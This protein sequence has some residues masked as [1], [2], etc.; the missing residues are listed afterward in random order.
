MVTFVPTASDNCPGVTT[1]S[2]P[3]S[4]SVFPVG[5]TLVTVTATDA[6]GNT[7]VCTFNVTVNDDED[8]VVTCPADIIVSND[9]GLCSAV[10]NF[11]PT[12]TDN[13][14][15]VATSSVP[16][17][18]SVFPVGTTEVTVTAVDASGNTDVC[19]FNVTVDDDEN[20]VVTCPADIIVSNDPGQCDAVVNFTPT[21]TDN[22]AGATFVSVPASGS[23]FPVGTTLVTVTATDAAGNT[24]VCTFNVT[25]DDD[26]NPVVTCPADIIV[27]ND[28]GQCDAVVTFTPTIS[29][30]CA[31][32]TFV[33]VPA[34]G[35]VF[36]V[37][38]TLVTVTGTDAAGNTNV[39]TF[40]VTVNDDEAPVVTCPADII[41]SNDSGFCDAVVTFTPTATDNCPGVSFVSVPASG[42]VFP[43]GITTVT[44]TATDA[45]G[46]TDVCTFDVTV[47][48]DENPIVTCPADIIVSND[49]GECGAVVDFTPTATDN[50]AG[51]TIASV[52][53]SGSVF[54]VGTTTVTVTATDA[55]GNMD[56]CTF[57]ITVNDDEDPVLICPADVVVENDLG[58]CYYVIV[59]D[60]FDPI[61]TDNCTSL[62]VVNDINGTSTL[63]G[64]KFLLGDTQ[65]IWTADD[66]NGNVLTCTATITVIDTEKPVIICPE[67]QTHFLE[68]GDTLWE[69]PDFYANGEASAT[70]NCTASDMLIVTQDPEVGTLLPEGV[71]TVTMTAKDESSNIGVCY[72]ELT[73]ETLLG[74]G[75]NELTIEN[76]ILYPNPSKDYVIIGNPQSLLL[77]KAVIYDLNDRIVKT[78]DL[79]G[80][81]IEKT[82]DVSRLAAAPYNIII[83]GDQGS[84]IK[85]M[86][87]E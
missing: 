8:P 87:K 40:N 24:N 10:V 18:G 71:Y 86:I 69:V 28:P 49:P 74:V 51:T 70:D 30:N 52:P 43:V 78:I 67:D 85:R 20:P 16:A 63:D 60:E 46:N 83:Y 81:G 22:C 62:T 38:T 15:G 73:I 29:D 35:S 77:N 34:S 54:P 68:N 32:A 45:A 23:V 53:A 72:F 50:C 57:D 39:C 61:T 41:V 19:T 11:T 31:G 66:G 59:G 26:E 14:P 84:I 5:T 1:S 79:R 37:G 21:V 33:S 3:A 82:I 36:P 6:S 55:A 9:P 65:V 44:V 13:C 76:I 42:S 17:S 7:D 47:N 80:M 12:A 4:G 58:E 64:E 56:V 48:D 27:S 75:D 25:V 2:V